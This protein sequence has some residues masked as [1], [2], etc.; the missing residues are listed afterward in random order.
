M[1]RTRAQDSRSWVVASMLALS[2]ARL[3]V[4]DEVPHRDHRFQDR[5]AGL[6]R[7]PQPRLAARPSPVVEGRE[8]RLRWAMQPQDYVVEKGHRLGVVLISTDHDYTL[9]H[10]PG[11]PMTVRT[12]LSSVTPPVA[13]PAGS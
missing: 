6:A 8:Y 3:R 1:A 4:P 9:R 11:T 2:A 5:D 12:G 7:R 10:P 13:P